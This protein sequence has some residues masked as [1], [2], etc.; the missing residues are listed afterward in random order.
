MKLLPVL[1]RLGGFLVVTLLCTALV[2][3]TLYRPFG[4]STTSY[5]AEFVD[6]VGL[7]KGSDVRIAGVRVGRVNDIEL[8]GEHAT[9]TFEVVDE[10]RVP[11]DA[12]A[13]IRYA[14]LLGARF[15]A[16]RPGG[17]SP[18][19]LAE[20]ATIPL[21]RTR[22]A[23]DLT[24]LFNGFQP[25]FSTLQPS[26]VNQLA[27]E[28]VAVFDG[29]GGTLNSLLA[30]VARLTENFAAQDE[31]IGEVLTNLRGVTDFALKHQPDFRRLIDSLAGLASGMAKSRG[32]LGDAIDAS[33]E[34]A[35]SLSGLMTDVRPALERDMRALNGIAGTLVDEKDQFAVVLR[36]MPDTLSA[37][38]RALEYAAWL[39]VYICNLTL[40]TGLPLA[41]EVDL[42]AGPHS[43]VCRR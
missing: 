8:T 1:L 5:Q 3:N 30:H 22:P 39:N 29:Q 7:K 42:S 10:Q 31:V 18:E 15:V 23:V 9:V 12:E 27:G 21:E 25:V 11:A 17:N 2:S 16:L 34:L 28:L 6:V 13:A 26:E 33:S 4:Q 14:D 37:L 43:E 35:R 19:T 32:Q 36:G 41:G 24:E 20:G 40:E 38:N